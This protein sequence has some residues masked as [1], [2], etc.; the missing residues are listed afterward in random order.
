MVRIPRPFQNRF[1]YQWLLASDI[2][3]FHSVYVWGS[4]WQKSRAQCAD[5][6][7]WVARSKIEAP[8]TCPATNGKFWARAFM[9]LTR[10]MVTRTEIDDLADE[11]RGLNSGRWGGCGRNML[12][13]NLAVLILAVCGSSASAAC[14]CRCVDGEVNCNHQTGTYKLKCDESGHSSPSGLN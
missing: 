8:R 6:S 9:K 4:R 1:V 7:R 3:A 12:A 5:R 14:V 2:F 13:F 10:I 11:Q